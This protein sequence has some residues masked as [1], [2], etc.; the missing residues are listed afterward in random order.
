MVIAF[1]VFSFGMILTIYNKMFS[2]IAVI[3]YATAMVAVLGLM[4]RVRCPSCKE[5]LG[6]ALSWPATWDLSISKKIKFCQF[7]G[8]SFDNEIEAE[9]K[10]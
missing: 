2:P 1:A 3:G 7:C 10:N 5:N 8:K 9:N 4:F 6:Y